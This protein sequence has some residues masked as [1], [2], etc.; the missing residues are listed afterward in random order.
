MY[1]TVNVKPVN[2]FSYRNSDKMSASSGK[3]PTRLGVNKNPGSGSGGTKMSFTKKEAVKPAETTYNNTATS[4]RAKINAPR[5]AARQSSSGGGR[6]KLPVI[7]AVAVII[8]AAVGFAGWKFVLNKP[9][10]TGGGEP[11]LPMRQAQ[12]TGNIEY[13]HNAI[14]ITYKREQPIEGQYIVVGYDN[15]ADSDQRFSDG[16]ISLLPLGT[17]QALRQKYQNIFNAD[18][19]PEGQRTIREAVLNMPYIYGVNADPVKKGLDEISVNYT[20]DRIILIRIKGTLLSYVRG[21]FN[22]NDVPAPQLQGGGN[23]QFVELND[24]EIM[25]Y[26]W[27]YGN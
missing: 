5:A 1:Y 11:T 8:L 14:D 4:S 17:A 2:N 20:P 22:G 16:H 18:G 27:S 23:F 10:D 9:A 25:D 15:W 24:I 13:K 3:T 12:A 19:D 6:S 21:S 26:N 7:I